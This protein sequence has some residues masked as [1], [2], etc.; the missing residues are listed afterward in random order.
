MSTTR[1]VTFGGVHV[2][3]PWQAAEP[4]TVE[5]AVYTHSGQAR[6]AE[7][8]EAELIR[9]NREVAD[10]LRQ[11]HVN[12]IARAGAELQQVPPR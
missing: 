3:G 1:G 7:L 5:L 9:L 12:R 6:I 2:R 11:L 10:A 8:T 4:V